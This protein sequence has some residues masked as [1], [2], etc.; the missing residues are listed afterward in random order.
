MAISSGMY[1]PGDFTFSAGFWTLLRAK[2]FGRK[3]D[4][5]IGRY[6][7]VAYYWRGTYYFTRYDA[8]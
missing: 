3:F 2:L 8:L 6:R 5:Q 7:V 4:E 1:P